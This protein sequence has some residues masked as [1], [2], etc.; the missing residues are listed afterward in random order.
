MGAEFVA[1]Q[2]DLGKAVKPVGL[3]RI[4]RNRIITV[5]QVGGRSPG[6]DCVCPRLAQFDCPLQMG[7]KGSEY[8]DR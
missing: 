3:N 7:F 5:A 6:F 2:V 1:N 8:V 4:F